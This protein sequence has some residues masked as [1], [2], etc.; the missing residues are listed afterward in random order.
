MSPEA[1]K[2]LSQTNFTTIDTVIVVAYLA[3]SVLI[4][5]FVRKYATNMT[6]YIGAGRKVG[7][8]L[9]VATMLGTEMGLITVMYSA[10]KGFSGGFAAFHIALI[11]GVGTLLVALTGFIVVPLREAKVLTIP[12]YYEKRFSRRTRILGGVLLS[13]AGILN[14]GLFLKVGAMFIVGATGLSDEGWALPAVMVTLLLLVLV[15]T[16]FG[17]MISVIL[18]DYIQFV[19]LSIGT[20]VVTG[21]AISKLGWDHIFNTVQQHMGEAGFNPL[22]EG[23][24]FGIYYVLWMFISAGLIGSAIWPTAVSRALAME[25]TAAVK[26]QYL[27]SS[28]SFTVRFMI[29]YFL[30]ISAYVYIMAAPEG[31]DLKA[32]FFPP[33]GQDSFDNLYAMP[34]FLGRLVPTVLLGIITAA[35]I[36]AFMSTHDSYFLCWSS[37]ITQDVIAPL[38]KNGLSE[39]KRIMLTRIIV[40]M[41]GGYVLYWGLFYEGKDDIWDYMAVSG[42]IYFNGAIAVLVGGIYWKKASTAGAIA[43]LLAGFTAILGLGPVQKLVGLQYQK[44]GSEDWEQRLSGDQVGLLSVLAALFAMFVFS[45]AFPDEPKE[46]GDAA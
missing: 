6:A 41:I 29:P 39:A 35:M 4:G 24:G 32:L 13:F 9:G 27:W 30:G 25:S 14:M 43:A 17:G 7:T 38:Q 16:T 26:R 2:A 21:I 34:V 3:V 10:Q 40:V 23:S 33:E 15:Y 37:V 45:L 44:P 46:K 18:T 28:I 19:V 36:A 20:L 11:A 12:E 31:Q 22:A 8:W 5:V 1:A 42:A